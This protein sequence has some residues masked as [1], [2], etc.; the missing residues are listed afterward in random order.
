MGD[1]LTALPD[2][3]SADIS[4]LSAWLSGDRATPAEIYLCVGSIWFRRAGSTNRS[5]TES[6]C[7]ALAAI[8]PGCL[9]TLAELVCVVGQ[10]SDDF[11]ATGRTMA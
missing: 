1:P 9:P 7:S 3:L 11:E 8:F 2:L 10:K 6:E 4:D 5:E